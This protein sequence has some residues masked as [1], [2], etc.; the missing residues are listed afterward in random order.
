MYRPVKFVAKSS[1]TGT[2]TNILSGLAMGF[3]SAFLPIL[4]ITVALI[5]AFY[6]G[7]KAAPDGLNPILFGFYATAIATMGK[8]MCAPYILAMDTLGPIV[9]N[10]GGIVEMSGEPKEVRK[11]TDRLDSLGNTTKALTKGYAIGSAVLAAFLL[12]AAYMEYVAKLTGKPFEVINLANVNTFGGAMLG[13]VLIFVFCGVALIAVSNTAQYLIEEVRRQFKNKKILSGKQR[14]DYAACVDITTQGALRQ[15]VT[16]GLIVIAFPI[17]TGV[18]LKAE[19]MGAF[20][21]IAT[22][23]GVLVGN[24]M[25]NGGGIWDNAKKLI[26]AGA[27][28]G[29]G[30]EA[31][32]AAVVG[33]TVGDPFK[34]TVGPSLHVVIKLLG[35]IT[36]VLAPLFV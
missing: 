23:V 26:E 32:K 29:K 21:M 11:K 24:F 12:I 10:A 20:L 13:G 9:D 14:P 33:D 18:I 3:E 8:L 15:M 36:L 6:A 19:A 30:S 22:V 7:T 4:S 31:H 27:Y 17:A 25:N 35:T 28:G 2:A 5:L 16:P 34:D 1:L